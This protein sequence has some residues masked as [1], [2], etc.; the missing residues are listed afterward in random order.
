M[1]PRCRISAR[2]WESDS[3]RKRLKGKIKEDPKRYE[4]SP[5]S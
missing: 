5:L 1:P 4:H 3:L 2:R